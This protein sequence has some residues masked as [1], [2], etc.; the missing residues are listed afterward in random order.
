M[1]PFSYVLK[2]VGWDSV[3]FVHIVQ[4]GYVF[5]QEWAFG[6]GYTK[7]LSFLTPGTHISFSN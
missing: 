5:E 3:Y 6:Y 4:N 2:F 1:H 7:T